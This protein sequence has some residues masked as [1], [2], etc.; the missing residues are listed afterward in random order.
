MAE[1]IQGDRVL[2]A[3]VCIVM[4]EEKRKEIFKNYRLGIQFEKI[5][6]AQA[7]E[8]IAWLTKVDPKDRPTCRDVL[9]S[10]YLA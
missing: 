10:D 7:A 2:L 3:T 6:D 1:N 9:E 5:D 8:C 4:T